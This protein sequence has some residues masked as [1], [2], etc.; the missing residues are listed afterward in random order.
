VL[1]CCIAFVP[2][3]EWGASVNLGLLLCIHTYTAVQGRTCTMKRVII[4]D[5]QVPAS[6][7]A[8]QQHAQL[9][10]PQASGPSS[11]NGSSSSSCGGSR[12]DHGYSGPVSSVQT[13]DYVAVLVRQ[14]G[15][16]ST[17]LSQPLAKTSIQEFAQVFGTSTPGLQH[18]PDWLRPL[19]AVDML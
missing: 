17:L 12:A 16:T 5:Q 6:L 13:G 15:G 8:L 2:L 3:Q 4:P 7:A 10:P 1:R 9:L 11:S 19:T 18:I 14:L